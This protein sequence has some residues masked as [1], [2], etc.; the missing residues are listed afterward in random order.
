MNTE[1]SIVVADDHPIF[2]K[3][4]IDLL[5]EMPQLESAVIT[6]VSDGVEAYQKIT[7]LRPKLAILD[8][9]MPGLKGL[10]VIRKL[11][12]EKCETRFIMITMHRDKSYYTEA[13][14]LGV[15]GYML[16]ENA[17][18]ELK[19]CVLKV[20]NGDNHLT[21]GL[22]A[23]MKDTETSKDLG[24]LSVLTATEKVILKLISENK[25]SADIATLLFISPNTVENH[26]SN[27]MKKLQL[28]G[29]NALLKFAIQYQGLI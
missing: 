8:Y 12:Q 26:R 23:L 5:K 28:E 24:F 14:Q 25:T 3:G 19:I 18:D 10:D 9:E 13:M 6:E 22:E 20:I 17:G 16:K 4:L 11:K 15:G 21:P 29:K 7:S 27:M 2:R 1:F